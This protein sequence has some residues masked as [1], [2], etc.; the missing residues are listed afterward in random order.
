MVL[1]DGLYILH[2]SDGV[3]WSLIFFSDCLT[4]FSDGL[5]VSNGNF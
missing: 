2:V 1:P 4:Y 3:I 5:M